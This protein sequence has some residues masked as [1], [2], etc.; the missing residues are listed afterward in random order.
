MIERLLA[1]LHPNESALTPL[2]QANIDEGMLREIAEADYGSK[3][4]E[5]YALLQPILKADLV[6]S[7]DFNL[8]EVLEIDPLVGTRR[9]GVESGRAGTARPL[10]AAVCL[11]CAGAI[12]AEI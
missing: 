11:R 8:R 2:F 4:D 5:C 6:A 10:D 12:C 7:D 3:A 1:P 9:S